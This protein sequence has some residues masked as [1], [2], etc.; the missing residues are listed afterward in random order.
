M[1]QGLTW[2]DD[3]TQEIIG[4]ELSRLPTVASSKPENSLKLGS[5]LPGP[6]QPRV[7]EDLADPEMMQ[8]Y[9]DYMI[10]DPPRSS[11]HMQRPPPDP[12]TFQ[13]P[14][15]R[16]RGAAGLPSSL[17]SSSF[18]PE[19]DFPLDYGEDY[20]S[21][22]SQLRLDG[23]SLQRL[24][25]LLDHYGL[26]VKDLS[27]DQREDLPAALKQLKSS[28]TKDTHGNDAA[29]G[30][31]VKEGAMAYKSAPPSSNKSPQPE[32]EQKVS[33]PP[34]AAHVEKEG[35]VAPALSFRIRPNN[36]TA[37][38]GAEKSVAEKH[39]LQSGAGEVGT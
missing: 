14:L 5:R 33:L 32:A 39:L 4:R 30:K 16:H 2:K 21:Q 8:Q 38:D 9:V 1:G 29:A 6:V 13:K 24:A 27:P 17:S 20:I 25:L 23:R 11:V 15:S 28:L 36:L 22:V 10:L 26:E 35:A 31:K 19:L 3:V 37:A 12:Y 7:Q 18:F 34:E